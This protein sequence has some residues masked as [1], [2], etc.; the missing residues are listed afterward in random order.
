MIITVQSNTF[1]IGILGILWSCLWFFMVTNFP[2]E[3]PKISKK[4]LNYIE[5]SLK[6]ES[7]TVVCTVYKVYR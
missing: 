5:R 6:G 4:E 7:E 1:Y 2:S 3:H